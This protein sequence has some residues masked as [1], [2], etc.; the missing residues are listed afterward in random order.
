MEAAYAR[1]KDKYMDLTAECR[2]AGLTAATNPVEIGCRGFVGTSTLHFLKSMGV[3]GP[4]LKK[5]LKNLAEEAEQGSFWLW[6]RRKDKAW[7]RGG[8]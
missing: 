3:T 1:K 6:L 7:G 4:K 8:S 2:E 5:A